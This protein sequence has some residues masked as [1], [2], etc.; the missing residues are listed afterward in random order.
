MN[1]DEKVARRASRRIGSYLKAH[2]DVT[3]IMICHR[4][5]EA[6]K[7]FNLELDLNG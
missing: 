6:P 2:K 5:D 4:T 1:L 3:A 7:C